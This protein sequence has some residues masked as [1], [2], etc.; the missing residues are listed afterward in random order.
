MSEERNK[1]F[2]AEDFLANYPNASSSGVRRNK[3]RP[4]IPPPET[5]PEETEPPNNESIRETLRKEPTEGLTKAE[6][7]YKRDYIDARAPIGFS[8]STKHVGIS[9]T[10]HNKINMILAATGKSNTI[11]GYIDNVLKKHF[12][13][14]TPV[15]IGLLDKNR[16]F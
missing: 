8:K 5:P 9:E 2:D 1:G 15:I 6:S 3:K 14:L 4:E 11:G 13:D 7:A 12:E 16:Q 10:Y